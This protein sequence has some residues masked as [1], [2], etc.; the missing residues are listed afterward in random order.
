VEAKRLS[1]DSVVEVPKPGAAP[2]SIAALRAPWDE[3]LS[4]AAEGLSE[5]LA[6]FRHYRLTVKDPLMHGRILVR[7][8]P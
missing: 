4:L 5:P 3:L 2:A 8:V 7:W 1:L 6:E